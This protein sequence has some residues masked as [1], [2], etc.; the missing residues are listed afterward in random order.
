MQKVVPPPA[1]PLAPGCL[2]IRKTEAWVSLARLCPALGLPWPCTG[3]VLALLSWPVAA[4]QDFL[5]YPAPENSMWA[6]GSL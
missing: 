3:E 2:A 4:P 1:S 6:V 5:V